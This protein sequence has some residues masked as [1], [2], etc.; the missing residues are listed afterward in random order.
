MYNRDISHTHPVALHKSKKKNNSFSSKSKGC[1]IRGNAD[2]FFN[3][4]NT[5]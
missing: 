1:F 5:A 4:N 2:F 3:K